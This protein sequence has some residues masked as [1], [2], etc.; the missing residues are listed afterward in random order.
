MTTD[1]ARLTDFIL[2]EAGYW[3]PANDGIGIV[4]WGVAEVWGPDGELKQSVEFWNLVTD[5]GDTYYASKAIVGISPA[6]AAAP[7]AVNGMKL[8]TGTTAVAKNGAGAALVT[9]AAAS[10][11]VFDTAFPTAATKGAGAGA[12]ISYKSTWAAGVAT[13]TGLSEVAIVNDQATNATTT[14]ANTIARAL[15][16]PVV[17]KGA[18]DTLT[19][20]WNHDLLGA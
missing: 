3:R 6:N 17:N 19:V 14:A 13:V 11:V 15:L 1:A 18:S 8:G 20:T 16:S 10:N 7:T 9:Y 2:T 12:R 5:V 4:G